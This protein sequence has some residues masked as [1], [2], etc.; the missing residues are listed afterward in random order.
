ML[1]NFV[2]SI[3]FSSFGVNCN[4]LYD[5]LYICGIYFCVCV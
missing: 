4:D 5:D 2:H 1:N 3:L